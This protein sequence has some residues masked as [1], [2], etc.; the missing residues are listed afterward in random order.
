MLTGEQIAER[1]RNDEDLRHAITLDIGKF[2]VA[3]FALKEGVDARQSF[4]GTGTLLL[5]QN[6]GYILTASHVWHEALKASEYVGLA[7]VPDIT[8]RYKVSTADLQPTRDL[9]PAVWNEWGPDLILLRLSPEYVSQIS[10]YKIFYSANVD[11]KPA[12]ENGAGVDIRSLLGTPAELGSFEPLH[13][14][15]VICNFFVDVNAPFKEQG[16]FDFVDFS[17]DVNT[18]GAP[19][20]YRGV[21]GGGLWEVTVYPSEESKSGLNW[22]RT[23]KGVAFWQQPLQDSKRVVRCHGPKSLETLIGNST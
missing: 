22:S 16:G 7:L 5:R 2:T 1:L 6:E 8:Q 10:A 23:L 19:S 13:A 12:P 15:L 17:F 18:P 21:S 11:G 20:N 14:D 4:A 3:M 9:H